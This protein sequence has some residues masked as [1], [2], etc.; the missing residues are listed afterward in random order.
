MATTTTTDSLFLIGFDDGV[1]DLQSCEFT[2]CNHTL[3]TTGYNYAKFSGD[4]TV[5]QEV[6]KFMTQLFPD[7]ETHS[8]V[9]DW[10]ENVH[11]TSI[12]SG[13]MEPVERHV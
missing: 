3:P 10:M 5:C 12:S 2:P 1:Y 11:H 13:E 9:W 6:K 8:Q 7:P 4:E